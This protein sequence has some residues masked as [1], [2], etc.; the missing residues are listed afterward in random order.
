M[1]WLA[2]I[3]FS[4]KREPQKWGRII[5]GPSFDRRKQSKSWSWKNQWFESVQELFKRKIYFFQW[6]VFEHIRTINCSI[7]RF[8]FQ[9]SPPIKKRMN[10]GGS[11][12]RKNYAN[13]APRLI[14]LVSGFALHKID[15]DS[16]FG[17][18]QREC[19]F[20]RISYSRHEQ[21][22]FYRTRKEISLRWI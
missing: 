11:T 19:N 14:W 4:G 20:L 1:P 22:I 10:S 17:V 3:S 15:H 13:S 5:S 16:I 21:P 8:G 9:L 7:R 6:R 18:I 12:S 2:S